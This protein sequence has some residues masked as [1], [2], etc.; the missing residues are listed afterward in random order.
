[1]TDLDSINPSEWLE[2]D[3][4]G[5]FASGSSTGV[6]ARRY[7]G[8]LV[9]AATPPTQRRML[10]NSV[11]VHA[12]TPSG[13]YALSSHRYGGDVIHPDGA[14]RIQTFTHEPWPTW[15]YRLPDGL[16]VQHEL[17]MCRNMPLVALFWR[18]VGRAPGVTLEVRPLLSGRD[19]HALHHENKAFQTQAK[20]DGQD[21]RFQPYPDAPQP[22]VVVRSNGAYAHQPHWYRGFHYEEESLR[23]FDACEDLASPGRWSFNL[24]ANEAVMILAA[25]EQDVLPAH[26]K[27]SPLMQARALRA[28]ERRRRRGFASPLHRAADHYIVRRGA[29]RSIIAGYPWFAD[30]GRDTFIAM[31]GLCLA[32]GRLGDAARILAEWST[33]V[34]QGMLP[35]RFPDE[36]EEPEYNAVDASLWYIIAVEEFLAL[37]ARTNFHVSRRDRRALLDAADAILTGYTHGTRYGIRMDQDGLLHS[38]APGMQLTWMDARVGDRVITPRIGK[39]VEVQALWINA[40]SLAARRDRGWNAAAGRAN[41]AFADRFWNAQCGWLNDVVDAD[42]QPGRID[43]TLRPNQIYAV[44]G[45]PL[46]IIDH[47]KARRIVEVVQ[48][49]LWTPLGLRSL[50]SGQADYTPRYFG[51]PHQRDAAYHQGTVWPYLAGPFVEAFLRVNHHM[52]SARRQA[53]EQFMQPLH[54]H[55]QQAGIGH[56]SEI[57]DAQSPHTPRGCPFQAWSLGELMRLELSVLP[58]GD[59]LE[60]FL[61]PSVRAGRARSAACAGG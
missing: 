45:L 44:G 40:L 29:G 23:G 6:A 54:N 36:G 7:H 46:T 41:R 1:M 58:D 35:N 60:R 30:W 32:T 19:Y 57:A 50:A 17:F 39:P 15:R 4:L 16:I 42:N 38:G 5:G 55:L 28:A 26:S 34:S 3:G 14:E 37:A 53:R 61:R 49:R 59:I 12:I 51:G 20:I 2:T 10:V 43:S 22:G 47:E 21:V 52:P 13:R 11:E 48:T 27:S 56:I 33:A 25:D 24:S 18:L 8:L 9:H 31:R